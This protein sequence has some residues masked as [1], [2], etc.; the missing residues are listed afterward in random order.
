MADIWPTGYFGAKAGFGKL[1]TPVDEEKTVVVIGCG[2]VG[3]CAIVSALEYRPRHILAVDGV[4]SRLELAKR[5]GAQP[6]NFKT[7]MDGLMQRLHQVTDGRG[8]D[9]VVE[10]VG[11]AP[12][13]RTAFDIVRPWGVI[14]SVG[15][16]NAEESPAHR[17]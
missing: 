16:H 7:D 17:Q 6:F 10:V 2:P 9:I 3:L 14:S 4:D 8:A 5:L 12:A 1:K 13:L 15:V 11:L